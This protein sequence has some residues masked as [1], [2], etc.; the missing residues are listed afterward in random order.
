MAGQGDIT[1]VMDG[2][3]EQADGFDWGTIQ[4][5]V[6]GRRIG[7]SRLTFGLSEIKPG[8]RN[9]RH[10]HP[11]CDE[12]LYVL[13]GEIDHSLGDLTYHLTPGMAIHIPT[14]T[15]HQA[16]NTGTV[17]ARLIIAFSSGDRQAVMLDDGDAAATSY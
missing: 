12:V 15:V 2:S 8:C 10:Y 7:D 9:P 11:N 13:E 4:W 14:G 6:S 3:R 16:A 5:L 1:R 17:V